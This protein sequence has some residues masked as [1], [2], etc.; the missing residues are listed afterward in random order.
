MDTQEEETFDFFD[1][2]LARQLCEDPELFSVRGE[3]YCLLD[4][5]SPCICVC[6]CRWLINVGF[7]CRSIFFLQY[8]PCDWEGQE[9]DS[10]DVF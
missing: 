2:H 1:T 7:A 3:L 10:T 9:G 5:P 8:I 4:T 6:V